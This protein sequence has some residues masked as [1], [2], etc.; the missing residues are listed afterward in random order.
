M[1]KIIEETP[2]P[3]LIPL[4]KEMFRALQSVREEKLGDLVLYEEY[5]K[6]ATKLA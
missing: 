6:G 3:Y 2:L 1:P 4:S 5:Q